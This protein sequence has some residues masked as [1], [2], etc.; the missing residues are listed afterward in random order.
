M[1]I[2]MLMGQLHQR[3]IVRLPA[4]P[5]CGA[6]RVKETGRSGGHFS[7]ILPLSLECS[8]LR[9]LLYPRSPTQSNILGVWPGQG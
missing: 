1:S 9:K 8:F 4:P 5:H 2:W 6:D 3:N 7:E